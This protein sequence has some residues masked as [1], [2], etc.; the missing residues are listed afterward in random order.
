MCASDGEELDLD[1]ARVFWGGHPLRDR[2]GAVVNLEARGGG[3][4]AMMFETGIG[5]AETVA[6]FADSAPRIGGGVTSNALAVFVYRQ[7][8]NGTDFTIPARRGVQGLNFAFIGRPEQYHAASS[9]RKTS[10]RER[11]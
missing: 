7:M 8:P 11:G 3:G 5:N 2:I 9:D 1:G 4:R 6:L 10:C